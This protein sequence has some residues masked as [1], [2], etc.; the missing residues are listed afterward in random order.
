MALTKTPTFYKCRTCPYWHPARD[1]VCKP[2][3]NGYT[4]AVLDAMYPD[5]DGDHFADWRAV[6]VP[7]H[8]AHKRPR[9]RP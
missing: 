4:V 2:A 7:A 5:R 9:V 1:K 3:H 6:R 8:K